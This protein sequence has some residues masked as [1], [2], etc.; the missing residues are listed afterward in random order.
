MTAPAGTRLRPLVAGAARTKGA[1]TAPLTL[2]MMNC[3]P[4]RPMKSAVVRR[5]RSAGVRSGAGGVG[6]PL[7]PGGVAEGAQLLKEGRCAADGGGEVLDDSSTASG[8]PSNHSP[9]LARRLRSWSSHWPTL[10]T[11]SSSGR[12][13][14]TSCAAVRTPARHRCGAPAVWWPRG[15]RRCRA[16]AGRRRRRRQLIEQRKP[17]QRVGVV[18]ACD[19]RSLGSAA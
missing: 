12:P 8:S 5:A 7:V 17:V 11:S 6:V 10:R 13:R 1:A 16:G 18:R 9:S 14:T 19:P 15:R 2:L 4:A 3:A